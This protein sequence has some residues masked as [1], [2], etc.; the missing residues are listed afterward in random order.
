MYD[1]RFTRSFLSPSHE[2]Q[3][4]GRDF[5]QHLSALPFTVAWLSTAHSAESSAGPKINMVY[6]VGELFELGILLSYLL[7]L[8]GLLG[9]GSFYV[10]RQVLVRRELDL[11]A[12]EL[13]V[14]HCKHCLGYSTRVHSLFITNT[15]KKLLPLEVTPLL[16][17]RVLLDY[18]F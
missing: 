16:H 2:D 4:R 14:S 18:L 3:R 12:K 17:P 7:I 8:L 6:E 11:S 1:A 9:A 10:V 15:T 5:L 13:Q